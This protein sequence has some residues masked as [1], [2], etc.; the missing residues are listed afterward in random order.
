MKNNGNEK[1]ELKLQIDTVESR[2]FSV[3]SSCTHSHRAA[4]GA[5]AAGPAGLET[6]SHTVASCACPVPARN[7]PIELLPTRESVDF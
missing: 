7:A 2:A 3:A 1:T 5:H 6:L 4:S